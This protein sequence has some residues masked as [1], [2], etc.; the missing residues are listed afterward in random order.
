MKVGI[1][2]NHQTHATK[3]DKKLANVGQ[4]KHAECGNVR[5]LK[6]R[7]LPKNSTKVCAKVCGK[8]F[9][10][11]NVIEHIPFTYPGNDNHILHG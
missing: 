5:S 3:K 11:K 2:S 8:V 4:T 1:E 7:Q 10:T 9:T 6:T